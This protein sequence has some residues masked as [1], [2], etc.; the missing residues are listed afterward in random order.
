MLQKIENWFFKFRLPVL[1]AFVLITIVMAYFAV[2]IRMDAGFAKQLPNSHSFVKTY[3]EYQDDLSGTN[4]ITVALRTTEGDIFTKEYLSNLFNLNNTI[5]YLPGVNQGSMQSLWTPNI[6]VMRVTEEGFESSEVIPGTVIPENLTPEI[7]ENI[8][9]RIL[10]GGHV[11]SI[12]ANDFTSSLIKVELTEYNPKTGEKLDYLKLGQEIETIREQY[13]IDEYRVEITGFAKMNSDIPNEAYNVVIFFGLAFFLTV[14]AVYWYSRSWTLTF[15]PLICSLTSLIWQF[16]MLKILGFGLDPLAILV[17][18]LVFAIGVSHGIQQ[19]N[20]ITKEVIEGE[21]AEYAA[22]ASFSRLLV[23]GSMALVTDLVGF[24]TL[25]LLPIGMIQELGI[26]A[27]IGVAFKIVTNLIMLPLAASYAR[28]NESFATRAQSAI[29]Y[30][31]NLMGFFGKLARP[32]EAVITLSVSAVLFIGAVYLAS[33]R[34]VGDL[35]A[36]APELRPEARF[37]QDINEITKRY[38]VTTDVLVV[39]TEASFTGGVNPCR[40]TYVMDAQNNLHWYLE[41]IPGV[42]KVISLSSIAKRA[43]SGYAEGNLK[44]SYLPRNEQALGFA[45]SVVDP[46]TG[47]INEQCSIM[48]IYVFTE[49]H[50]A[51]T[52]NTVISSIEEYNEKFRELD[53]TITFKT[54]IAKPA[55]GTDVIPA[56]DSLGGEETNIED[57]LNINNPKIFTDDEFT[58]FGYE[59]GFNTRNIM[60]GPGLINYYRD[61]DSFDDNVNYMVGDIKQSEISFKE[62]FNNN[63]EFE[64]IIFESDEIKNRLA[65]GSVGIQYATNEV[66]EKGELPMM[67]IVYIVIFI[68][69]FVTYLDW[70]ATI[71]CTVP[72]TFATML[73]YAFMDLA[74]IG[75]KVSTLPVMVL[76]VGVGVDYAF[77]I[78]NRTQT[79]LKEGMNITEA[80]EHTFANTGAAVVFTAITLAI[81]VSTWSF[82]A[83]KFQADMGSLLTF[84]FLIN[85]VCAMTTL[86]ALAVV[87]DKL[88]PRKITSE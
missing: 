12:V 74:Q 82:S 1:A 88:F 62:F 25:I 15:L 51:T 86:P 11:G 34:Y 76:A 13:E 72:L 43:L 70:R 75:L 60:L 54:L 46:S 22:R 47:L 32:R 53:D 42:S 8:K 26:T 2:Q 24:G 50:K 38:N 41:N 83:L 61:I 17:P 29:S 71:C 10:T 39:I 4:S 14:L 27:S 19:V 5:R 69:V 79:R 48:P 68:L 80:F 87:L 7:I 59:N 33:E 81:G 20:Q 28:Y 57:L 52:L 49:D 31:Q 23:P 36:G 65:S 63:P 45:T 58:D 78:Y 37:N 67:I 56:V 30:R 16:G 84:M 18:F 6:R 66:I 44:W 40:S 77:Y 55:E 35:H 21:T 3:Y 85:M 9:E 64:S 73:G